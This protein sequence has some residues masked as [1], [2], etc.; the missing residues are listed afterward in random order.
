MIRPILE[1]GLIIYDNCSSSAAQTIER[2]QRQAA[3]AC[4]GA[5][6][7]TS[8]NSLLTELNWESLSSRRHIY[9]LITYYK[10]I[11]N[12]Y[13]PYLSKLLPQPP[14]AT[15]NL[16]RPQPLRPKHNRLTSTYN[17]YFSSTTRAWNLLP[18]TTRNAP[19]INTFKI[20][21]RGTNKYNPYHP[22]CTT[23]QGVWLTRIR[24]G[25]SALNAHRYQYNFINSPIC[26]ICNEGSENSYHF[27]I[28]CPAHRNAR[29]TLFQ[30]LQNNFGID[31][32][33]YQILLSTILEGHNIHP[34]HHASLLSCLSDFLSD[35]D[36]FR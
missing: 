24:M 31:I 7:H 1:Y 5:Y 3:L 12:I 25:L 29:Q 15:Y 2:V 32:T 34:R 23:K 11:H 36:R 19:S 14:P 18:D 22:K 17:S 4:T 28:S 16:R 13:P 26:T 8:Y 20:L 30:T 27:F 35:T 6:R 33:N 9:K 21:V 10:I